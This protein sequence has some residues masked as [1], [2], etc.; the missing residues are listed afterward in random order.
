M[1]GNIERRDHIVI[2]ISILLTIF[3]TVAGQAMTHDDITYTQKATFTT[4]AQCQ[5]VKKE[6][7]VCVELSTGETALYVPR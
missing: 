1:N 6:G 3:F 5:E 2:A 7:N 4:E